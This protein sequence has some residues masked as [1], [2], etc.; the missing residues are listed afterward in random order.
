MSAAGFLSGT[1]GRTP[2]RFGMLSMMRPSAEKLKKVV[3]IDRFMSEGAF[4]PL[5]IIGWFF[6]QGR[7]HLVYGLDF[8]RV[9]SST[10]IRF[11]HASI[12]AASLRSTSRITSSCAVPG[13]LLK[14]GL[15]IIGILSS[16]RTR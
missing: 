12:S 5:E 3:E 15:L 16:R 9:I 2:E 11:A 10:M 7:P 6:Q 14:R 8:L 1:G 13:L 4:K